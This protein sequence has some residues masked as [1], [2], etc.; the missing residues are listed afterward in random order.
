[1]GVFDGA[2]KVARKVKDPATDKQLPSPGALSYGGI[3]SP[4]GLAGCNGADA[5]IVHGD[6][7]LE[8]L[9][10]HTEHVL[11]EAKINSDSNQTIM[12]A[13]D[14]T[15]TI[16]GTANETIIGPHLIANM[17]VFN[18]TRLG[19]HTQVHGEL[20]MLNDEDGK[21]HYGVRQYTLYGITFEFEAFHFECGLNHVEIKG[22][23]PYASFLDANATLFKFETN[24]LN[25]EEDVS[26]NDIDALK[27]DIQALQGRLGALEGNAHG[28]IASAGPD[29]NPTPLI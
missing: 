16:C 1:M 6:R 29:P 20:E 25:A 4:I 15:E 12:V 2:V 22:N 18:E 14:Q 28:C 19:A 3:K 8:S 21:I 26:K 27:S 23:H 13:G 17:N 11:G 7:W 10:K 5:Q 24:A 9:G